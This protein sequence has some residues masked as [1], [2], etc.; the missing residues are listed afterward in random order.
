MLDIFQ[1]VKSLFKI[2]R[3]N[4]DGSIFRLHYRDTSAGLIICCILLA[5]TQFVGKPI[6]CLHTNDISSGV[7]NTWCW[8]HSTYT[9]PTAFNKIVGIEVPYPG[10][11]NSRNVLE[12]KVYKFYQWVA[13]CLFFQVSQ[14]LI[15]RNE[16]S[17]F[18]DWFLRHVLYMKRM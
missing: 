16:I 12:K 8:I 2:Q 13:L 3:T 17:L 9:V 15:N 1:R 6:E 7:L 5:A 18:H 10:I 11:D 4:I 14:C